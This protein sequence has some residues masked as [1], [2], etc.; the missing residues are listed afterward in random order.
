MPTKGKATE[1]K[2]RSLLEADRSTGIPAA[3]EGKVNRSHYARQLGCTPGAL[4]NYVHV[5]SEYEKELSITTGPMRHFG[6]MRIWLENAYTSKQLRFDG[7]IL[8]RDTFSKHFKLRGGTFMVRH[9]AIRNLFQEFDARAKSEGYV[10][11]EKQTDLDRLT[12]AL[13]SQPALN[14]D[15]LTINRPD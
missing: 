13:A 10:S 5:F 7:T 9:E 2:L 6:D 4:S 11:A 15:R 3:K 8:E 14:K 12:A 1:Q